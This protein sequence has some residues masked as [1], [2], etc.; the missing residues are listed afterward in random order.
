[1]R[2]I[3][4]EDVQDELYAEGLGRV[5]SK[6]MYQHTLELQEEAAKKCRRYERH[7]RTR[8]SRWLRG[9]ARRVALPK[10]IDGVDG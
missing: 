6:L 7:W 8:L 9:M 2:P 3:L 5:L 10:L 4:F 1:M